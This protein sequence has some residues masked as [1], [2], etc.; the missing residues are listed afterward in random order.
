MFLKFLNDK[1]MIRDFQLSDA[2]ALVMY[3][4]NYKI[5]KWV[6]DNFPYPYTP[7]DAELWISVSKNINDGIYYAIAYEKELIGGIG[8]KFKE[9]VY[10]F[11]WELGYW[12]GEPFWNKGIITDAIKVFTKYLFSNY[13][14]R[15]ITANVY[16]GNKASMKALTKAGFKLDGVIRKAVFKEKVFRDLYV[17]SILR[18]EVKIN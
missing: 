17:Y 10:K 14:I 3:A 5:F 8:V 7:R 2:D 1:Y 18:E 4:N 11:S 9:D 6:K 15:S 16:E 13:N 12:L